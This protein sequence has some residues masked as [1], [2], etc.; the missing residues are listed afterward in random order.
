MIVEKELLVFKCNAFLKQRQMNDLYNSI[1]QQ[2]DTGIII[3]PPYVEPILV[4]AGTE[5]KISEFVPEKEN[6]LDFKQNGAM[7]PDEIRKLYDITKKN[8]RELV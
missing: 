3:V 8:M 5:I 2:K 4:P 6:R 1:H 7:N